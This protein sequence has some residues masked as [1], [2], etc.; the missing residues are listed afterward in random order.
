MT[1]GSGA[2]QQGGSSGREIAI[3][4]MAGRF[5]GAASIAEFWE[6][7]KDGKVTISR[8]TDEEA[9]DA[10]AP[11]WLRDSPSYIKAGGLLSD[12]DRFDHV[13]FRYTPRDAAALDPQQRTFLECAWAAMENAG[14]A[15]GD[16]GPVAGVYAGVSLSTYLLHNLQANAE[17][18][19]GFSQYELMLG[20]D[21]DTLATRAAYHL[22]LTGPAVTV[23]ASCSSSLVAIHLAAQ[24]LLAV[25]CD[26]ALAGGVRVTVPQKAGYQAG[27]GGVL[28][29]DGNVYPFDRRANGVVA[30]DGVAVVVLKTLAAAQRDRDT[31][32][33][34]I[35]GSAVNND[36]NRRVG[37]TAPSVDGQAAV[38]RKAYA[39]AGV[40][41]RTISYV[42]THGTA[43][44]LGDPIEFT[45]LAEVFGDAGAR[46]GS[47]ALGAVKALVGH[48]DAAAGVTGLVK[49]VL[50][51]EHRCIP[52][53]PYFRAPNPEIELTG[54]PFRIP[55]EL[56]RWEGGPRPL[57]AAVSSFGMGG[58]NA[59]VVLEEAPPMRPTGPTCRPAQLLVLSAASAPAL[60]DAARRLRAHLAAAP[61]NGADAR[62]SPAA[63]ADIAF[64]AQIGRKA[65][66]FRLAVV[67]R[68]QAEAVDR[69]DGLI[70]DAPGCLDGVPGRYGEQ[71][72]FLFPGQG[73]Q[74]RGMAQGL[75]QV[76]PTFREW[77]D[78]CAD[79]LD[80]ELPA[81][82]RTVV[83]SDSPRG[84]LDRT[85]F[86]QPAIFAVEYALA[87]LWLEWGVRPW[88]MLGHSVG[89]YTAACLAGT[90]DLPDALRLIAARGRMMQRL[91]TG[92]MAAVH[93]PAA[94]LETLLPAGVCLAAVNGPAQAVISGPTAAVNELLTQLNSRGIRHTRLPASHAFHSSMMDPIIGEFREF[95]S[96]VTMRPPGV[97]FVSNVTGRWITDEQAVSPAYWAR[98]LR[99]PVRFHDG[100]RQLTD[101]LRP[102]ILL[103]AGPGTTLTALASETEFTRA[104][105]AAVASL[106]H[107]KRP[108]HDTVAMLTAAG[109]LFSRGVTLDWAGLWRH[110]QRARVPLPTYPFERHRHWIGAGSTDH[111]PDP[112]PDPGPA[113]AADAADADITEE[114]IEIW[115]EQLGIDR[116]SP[117]SDFF[118]LGG[119]SLLATQV[120]A[121]VRDALAVELPAA[122]LFEAPTLA[123]FTA[124]TQR[125]ALLAEVQG[126]SLLAQLAALSQDELDS[127][128]AKDINE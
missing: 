34:V 71:V 96:T 48:L 43:T 59:H 95:A 18:L 85:E 9:A 120:I 94:S 16:D 66:P 6:V 103:E 38:I 102:R 22:D 3:I 23:Q 45:A 40:S 37:F 7:I 75:Y 104:G 57:R 124:L 20:N 106:S 63:L 72:A 81:D 64:T 32:H 36:G 91:P 47:C 13:L 67:C 51:L 50:A 27:E 80:G 87:Q 121:R 5:P 108:E 35:T 79:L 110:E 11:A 21:K 2:S 73:V 116:I 90:F 61:S 78:R 99:E 55:V 62:L 26:L 53:N 33:A 44:A 126:D 98:H 70:A 60:R 69:L 28:S 52:P 19:S 123:E 25:D 88:A 76:E 105:H 89:E 4:G 56:E 109:A 82:L 114:I 39:A 12:A 101:G 10:G 41:A 24:A 118:A 119:H 83:S 122:A 97:R 74:Q 117:D 15:C 113:D 128:I 84:L 42:E 46:S 127:L 86:A 125:C 107:P 92:L 111:G 49:T 65:K 100:V 8:F 1:G 29:Q 17:A 93:M 77:F 58:T 54:S 14:Y 115:R 112:D 30:G 68:D 31:I